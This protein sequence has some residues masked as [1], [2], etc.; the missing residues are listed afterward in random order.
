VAV[1]K[2]KQKLSLATASLLAADSQAAGNLDD[3]DALYNKWSV[4]AG[5]LRYEET[6]YITVDTYMAMIRGDLSGVDN[7]KLGIVFD[8]LSGS[9]PT[10]ALP[11]SDAVALTGVSGGGVSTG[12]GGAGKTQFDD[13]RLAIDTTWTHE[14]ERLLR[15][16]ATA[17]ISVEGDYTAVGGSLAIEQDSKDKTTTYTAA[18]GV[19]AD[20]VSRSDEST[21]APLSLVSAGSM[22]GAGHKNTFEG[23][24]GATHVINQRTVAMA[25]FSYSHSLGYHT[26]PYKIISIA[27]SNDVELFDGIVYEHRPDDRERFVLYGKVKHELPESGHH[28]GLSYR[29]HTDNWGI[30]SHTIEGDYS[31]KMKN[32]DLVE[33]FARAYHQEAADFYTRTII[34]DGQQ[35]FNDINL[36]SH[37]S[38][39]VRL[40]EMFSLTAGVKYRHKTSAKGSVDFRIAY[41]HRDYRDAV[42]DTEGTV[43]FVVDLGKAFD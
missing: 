31:F 4:D 37:A 2:L 18:I 23:L 5:Y 19:A 39:D 13:T 11:G 27:D 1:T 26:D 25:N 40:S 12:G 35:V 38:A 33:P 24:I 8:T 15:S 20:K 14:W 3:K 30:N 21:P 28:L 10:G 43:F 17:A 6:G 32:N 42:L 34:S 29:F 16:K 41:I 9:T 36:P 22:L 7:I